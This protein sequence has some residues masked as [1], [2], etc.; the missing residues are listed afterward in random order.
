M[1][2]LLVI[3]VAKIDLMVCLVV[4]I[5]DKNFSCHFKFVCLRFAL[6][7]ERVM[8]SRYAY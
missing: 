3:M 7:L 2:F 6:I 1:I 4:V 8:T 5:H